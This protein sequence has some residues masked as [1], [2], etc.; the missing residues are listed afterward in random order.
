LYRLD[1]PKQV[2]AG[3]VMICE[4][5]FDNTAQNRFNPD[6]TDTVRFGEQSWEEMFIGYFNYAE[7]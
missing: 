4:G 3:T 5:W 2:P 7:N 1:A 6:P